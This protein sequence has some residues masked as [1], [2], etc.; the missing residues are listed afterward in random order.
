MWRGEAG[1][2]ALELYDRQRRVPQ[3]EYVQRLTIENKRFVTARDPAD[4]QKRQDEI[5]R[6]GADKALA[7]EYLLNSSMI[8]MVRKANAI[9]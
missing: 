6:I 2:T 4:R 1:L 9:T 8:A 3:I 5:R 7:Y